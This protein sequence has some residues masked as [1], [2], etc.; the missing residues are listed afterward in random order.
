MWEAEKL[1][2]ALLIALLGDAN[3]MKRRA[4]VRELHWR[5]N[6]A[7]ALRNMDLGRR[8]DPVLRE[9]AARLLGF[10]DIPDTDQGRASEEQ[11]LAAQLLAH[12]M[13][14]Q[15][16]FIYYDMVKAAG[17]IGNP[18]LI[19]LLEKALERFGDDTEYGSG[20]GIIQ[21]AL[22]ALRERAISL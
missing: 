13:T 18:S 15:D 9:E 19:P 10:L 6:K 2:H 16:D 11:V 22:D 8:P 20:K 5:S 1:P 12:E 4:V 7:T 17:Q 3:P 21:S 14:S